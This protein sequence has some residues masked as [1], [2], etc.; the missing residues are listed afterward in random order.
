MGSDA[1]PLVPAVAGGTARARA[2]RAL[3]AAR[4]I[5][6]FPTL[7]NV[8]A[9]LG[10]ALVASRGAPQPVLLLRM[11]L[12]MLC[13]Q[14][15]IG[16]ANDYFDRDLDA[17][18]KRWKPVAAGLVPARSAAVL[19]LALSAASIA[20]AAT[21]VASG[22]LLALLGLAC[23]LAYDA[24]LKRT[25]FSA[26]PYMVAIPTLPLWVWVTLGQWRPALWWLVPV[27]ALIG[28]ALHL[29]NTIADIEDDTAGGVRGLAHRL[30]AGWSMRLGWV[31]FGLALAMTAGLVPAVSYDLRWYLPA[32][33]VAA[34]CLAA[35][36]AAYALRRDAAA[37]QL[38]FGLLG[39]GSA[40]LA[41]GWLAAVTG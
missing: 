5:H 41:T 18:T 38:G 33:A 15:A 8:A 13:A 17:R 1:I 39:I 34:M 21:L 23:G 31:A 25:V 9:T 32:A 11:L 4:I 30:G 3:R 14:S 29:Q 24:R 16:V 28:L 27:G 36:I 37:L 6:P 35:S 20:L 40:V 26:V 12:L 19:A 22:F 2:R 7:L 10:L